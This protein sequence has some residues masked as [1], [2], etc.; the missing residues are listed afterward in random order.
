M[1]CQNCPVMNGLVYCAVNFIASI[2]K[3]FTPVEYGQ[4]NEVL[5]NEVMW[6]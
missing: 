3:S 6:N 4:E 5:K 1:V 2:Q